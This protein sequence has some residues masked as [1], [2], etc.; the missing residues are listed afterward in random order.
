MHYPCPP[1]AQP[2][3]ACGHCPACGRSY[4]QPRPYAYYPPTWYPFV[5]YAG[6]TI[7]WGTA[8]AATTGAMAAVDFGV[9]QLQLGQ[10][11][12]FQQ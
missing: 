6:P 3:Q 2:C 1:Y 7:T 12:P 9:G 8:P 11:F 10:G 5:P 4:A